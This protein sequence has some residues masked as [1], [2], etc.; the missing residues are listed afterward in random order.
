MARRILL[1]GATGFVGTY[2]TPL[3][4]RQGFA[5]DAVGRAETGPLGPETDWR[6]F[7]HSDTD[8][9][10]HL[11][12]RAHVMREEAADTDAAYDQV[13]R[14]ATLSL[15]EQAMQAGIRRF[16]YVSSVKAMGEQGLDLHPSMRPVPTDPYGRSKLAAEEALRALAPALNT[17][18]LR[19]PLVYGPGVKANFLALMNAVN[20]GLP[21]PFGMVRNR[22]SLIS[23]RNLS[24]AL[25]HALD[26]PPGVYCPT[27]PE[28]IST[29]ALVR[30]IGK[31][32]GTNPMLLPVPVWMLKTL[33]AV[34]GRKSAIDRLTGDL[35]FTGWPPGWSPPQTAREGFAEVAAWYLA[36]YRT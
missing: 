7:L 21:L 20:K 34:L 4:R 22:R 36:E 10:I 29:P 32:M 19:P 1:T 2:L 24:D 23:L 18:V 26:C 3:L 13:N 25:I 12:G 28:P 30:G 5:V 8:G 16:V 15:A 6:P 27:D 9:I 14:G 35:T 11:A 31:A 17:V 33:G